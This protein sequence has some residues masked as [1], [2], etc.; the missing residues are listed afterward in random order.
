MMDT[1]KAVVLAQALKN[2]RLE[3]ATPR[4]HID[5]DPKSF[6]VR[7]SAVSIRVK[8]VLQRHRNGGSERH[9]SREENE[10]R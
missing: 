9:L 10:C 2:K 8:K 5:L 3:I 4:V 6:H 1:S 7:D